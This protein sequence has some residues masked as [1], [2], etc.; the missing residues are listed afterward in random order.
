M[1]I[2]PLYNVG[3]EG[4]LKQGQQEAQDR[5]TALEGALGELT[6]AVS[7]ALQALEY[8]RFDNG[9][10][11]WFKPLKQATEEAQA[12]LSANTEDSEGD[13]GEVRE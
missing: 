9:D 3:F 11:A 5:I 10:Y 6:T 12:L 1:N 4:G 8:M 2:G 13:E 7:G